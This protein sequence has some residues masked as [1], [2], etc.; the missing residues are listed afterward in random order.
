MEEGVRRA[1]V[2][3]PQLAWL[4]L[5]AVNRTQGRGTTVRLVVPS[6]PEVTCQLDPSLAEHELLAAEEYLLERGHIAP[7]NLGLTWGTYTITA[8]GLAWLDEGYPWP[9]AAPQTPAADEVRA[10]ENRPNAQEAREGAESPWWRR[11]SGA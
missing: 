3:T 4:V 8:T 7:A 2:D 11:V 5:E 10:R 9:S 6:A 1:R